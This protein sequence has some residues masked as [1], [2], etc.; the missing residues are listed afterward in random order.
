MKREGEEHGK[1]D[2]NRKGKIRWEWRWQWPFRLQLLNLRN[3]TSWTDEGKH[4][5]P[6]KGDWRLPEHTIRQCPVP[7][8]SSLH[9]YTLFSR[10]SHNNIFKCTPISSISWII[11]IFLDKVCHSPCVCYKARRNNTLWIFSFTSV[12]Y[13]FTFFQ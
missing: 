2:W 6:C 13:L 12:Y 1:N 11:F 3:S 8:Q 5:S 9:T 4:F 7:I 10:P